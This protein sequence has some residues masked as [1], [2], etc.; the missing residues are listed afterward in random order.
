VRVD[1]RM[2]TCA[3]GSWEMRVKVTPLG[4]YVGDWKSPGARRHEKPM[5]GLTSMT[6]R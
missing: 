1:N 2:A 3:M 5:D 6:Y 4:G